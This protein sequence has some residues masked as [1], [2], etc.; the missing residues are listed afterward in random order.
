[1]TRNG[2]LCRF[3]N[4]RGLTGLWA[5]FALSL[6]PTCLGQVRAETAPAERE[7]LKES[8]AFCQNLHSFSFDLELGMTMENDGLSIK[9]TEPYSIAVK[10]PRY[11]AVNLK[12]G[13]EG[14]Q[15]VCDG[16]HQYTYIAAGNKYTISAAATNISQIDFARLDRLVKG[17]TPYEIVAP[18]IIPGYQGFL[19]RASQK[20]KFIGREKT[21][22]TSCAHFG[23]DDGMGLVDLWIKEGEQPLLYKIACKLNPRALQSDETMRGSSITFSFRFED[24]KINPVIPA[25]RFQFTPPINAQLIESLNARDAKTEAGPLLGKPA[26]PFKSDLINGAQFD[27]ASH[28]DKHIVVLQFW[29]TWS[30]P[31]TRSLPEVTR[32]CSSLLDKDVVFCAINQGQD[33]QLVKKFLSQLPSVPQVAIENK[34]SLTSLYQVPSAPYY[35]IVDKKGVVRFSGSDYRFPISLE[36]RLQAL[37]SEK[38][39]IA[40]SQP[41]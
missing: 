29:A 38:P 32:I 25:V 19:T 12:S 2:T 40:T 17:P 18:L 39:Q 7:L 30:V 37:I 4:W 13:T 34:I 11:L 27:L 10:R 21:D 5:L 35:V 15:T 28:K 26:P 6:A 8:L 1:M 9:A 24:W 16:S 3:I 31:S 20:A 23:F 41:N 33:A 36:R 14:S 22:G